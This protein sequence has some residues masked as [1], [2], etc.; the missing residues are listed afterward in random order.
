MLHPEYLFCSLKTRFRV[1]FL[2]G[3][4]KLLSADR[5]DDW[6]P[7]SLNLYGALASESLERI[8]NGR[9]ELGRRRTHT[10]TQNAQRCETKYVY[11][12]VRS[13]PIKSNR[14]QF[15]R[16]FCFFNNMENCKAINSIQ[17]LQSKSEW[18]PSLWGKELT[19]ANALVRHVC[20][21]KMWNRNWQMVQTRHVE[22]FIVFIFFKI[23]YL[24]LYDFVD[25]FGS[26]AAH[27]FNRR[28]RPFHMVCCSVPF[29]FHVFP[30]QSFVHAL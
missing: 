10:H 8:F 24:L 30:R 27:G 7:F 2:H 16:R 29:F 18:I 26:P 19:C 25:V 13:H 11:R 22:P 28:R 20:K 3:W 12:L 9:T 23:N 14:K 4:T 1:R 21:S 6:W 5:Y 17:W 15:N